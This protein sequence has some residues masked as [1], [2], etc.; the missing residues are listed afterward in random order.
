MFDTQLLGSA[1]SGLFL[2]QSISSSTVYV[3]SEL[4]S[5]FIK[6]WLIQGILWAEWFTY[7]SNSRIV[8]DK[9]TILS[10][11]SSGTGTALK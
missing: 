3:I 6:L 7:M 11:N 9:V 8:F 4:E 10:M 1:S 5:G 2:Q